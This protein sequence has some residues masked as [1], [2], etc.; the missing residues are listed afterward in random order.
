[1]DADR[2]LRH[3]DGIIPIATEHLAIGAEFRIT[4]TAPQNYVC[5]NTPDGVQTVTLHAGENVVTFINKP[6]IKLELYKTSDDGNI[7]DIEFKL[8]KQNKSGI[9]EYVGTY[10]TDANGYICDEEVLK[11]GE[12][13]KIVETVPTDSFC[14]KPVKTFTAH[15]G[16]NT[17]RF[18]NFGIVTLEIIKR[19]SSA[20]GIVDGFKFKIERLAQQTESG[21]VGRERWETIGTYVSANGGHIY[22]DDPGLLR[23]GDEIRIEEIDLG[24]YVCTTENPIRRT[25]VKGENVFEFTNRFDTELLIQKE[26]DDGKIKG[27]TFVVERK[28]AEGEY[29]LLGEFETD[30]NGQIHI[31]NIEKDQTYKITETLP[32]GYETDHVSQE[33]TIRAGTNKV[34]FVNRLIECSIKIGKVYEGT[35]VPLKD[36]GFKLYD[37]RGEELAEGFTNEN[38]ELKFERLRVGNYTLKEFQAPPGFE[39]D[40]TEIPITLTPDERDITI[41]R[42]NKIIPGLIRVYKE[43]DKGRAMKGVTYLLEYSLDDTD[44]WLPIQVRDADSPVQCGYST[45]ANIVDGCITTGDDGIAEFAGLA[46]DNAMHTIKYRLTEVG[47]QDG[48]DLLPEPVFEGHLTEEQVELA[49][50]VVNHHVFEMPITGGNGFTLAAIGSALAVLLAVIILLRLP[51]KKEDDNQ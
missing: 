39:L 7:K 50:K 36:A 27:I 13:Y 51:K 38:G 17:V 12:T 25:L 29:S 42:E 8:Y 14:E 35:R 16:T 43:D 19:T 18:E 2:Q 44:T 20:D 32:Y 46:I 31:E 11:E 24:D 28:K 22:I 45:S 48:Y 10:L 9:F 33:I 47:T 41:T 4:E 34:T 40:E 30:E 15:L 26:S 6:V 3:R 23:I 5:V 21:V 49:Y 1:M 37:E